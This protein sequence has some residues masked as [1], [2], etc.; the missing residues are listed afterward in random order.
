MK[1]FRLF[2]GVVSSLLV[3]SS[4]AH[5]AEGKAGLPQMDV[6]YFAGQ[7]FWLAVCFA[8]LYV[9]MQ[10]VALPAVQ[11]TQDKRHALLTQDLDAARAAHASAAQVQADYEK[12]LAAARVQA[13][14]VLADSQLQAGKTAT[15]QQAEL[16]KV[17]N[18]RLAAAETK[19]GAARDA[20]LVEARS[21]VGDLAETLVAKVTGAAQGA[22]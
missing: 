17:L 4:V 20:A 12:T 11:Q 19:I 16:H 5:A 21:V 2:S 14:A 18:E 6:S 22:K 8:V 1:S 10:Y 13:H 15:A 9:L 3:A 7:L